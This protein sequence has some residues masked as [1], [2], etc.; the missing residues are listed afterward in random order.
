[1]FTVGHNEKR[2]KRTFT[3]RAMVVG[4]GQLTALGIVGAQLYRLQILESSRYSPLAD[5]NRITTYAL[6]P[7]RGQIFDRYGVPLATNRISH[8]VVVIPALAN[9]LDAVLKRLSRTVALDTKT[10]R[11]ILDRAKRQPGHLAIVVAEDLSFKDF[12][13]T[14]LDIPNTPGIRTEIVG[15]RRYHHGR[16][17]GHVVGHVG[18]V[19]EIGLGDDAIVRDPRLRIGRSGVE[20]GMDDKLRGEGGA[21]RFEVDAH[22]RVLRTIARKDPI[23][24]MDLHLTLDTALQR[25]IMQRLAQERRA[26]A[27]V[28]DI[29][30]GDILALASHPTYDPNLLVGDFDRES[31]KKL[32]NAKDNPLVNRA[33]RGLYPPGSTFKMVTELAALEKRLITPRRRLSCPGSYSYGGVNFR[34][35]NRGGHGSVDLHRALKESCDVYH[36]KL[37]RRLGISAIAKMARKLGLGQTY[38]CGLSGQKAGIVPDA[39]WKRGHMQ[40]P[41]FGGETIHASIGQGY[42]LSTPLQ[43]AVMTARIASGRKIEPRIVRPEKI[44]ELKPFPKLGLKKKNLNTVRRAMAAVVNEAGGTGH[45]AHL[46]EGW[47]TVAGKTG[48][49]QVASLSSRVANS[50]LDWHLRDHALFVS[51]LPESKPRYAVAV[52]VEHGGSGGKAAAPLARDV[53]RAIIARRPDHRTAYPELGSGNAN[54]QRG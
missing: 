52:I 21:E 2:Q 25:T 27:A 28:I 23:K 49:S 6:L 32:A 22:G 48:T 35:W 40:K 19:G 42:V 37:A 16:V 51:Y 38:P 31:W 14:N 36:Y 18:A 30:T 24:G 3:R 54:L 46:G 53:M 17:V 44:E 4:I 26:A 5:R 45:N 43:L 12:A 39:D 9:N 34:C 33:I 20:H 10:R 47:P 15:L 7:I 1:M 41:W 11:Q 29:R 50:A 13:T 8:Q